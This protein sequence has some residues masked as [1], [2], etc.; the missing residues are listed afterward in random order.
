MLANYVLEMCDKMMILIVM[1]TRDINFFTVQ[2]KYNQ[3]CSLTKFEKLSL[4]ERKRE[5]ERERT[6]KQIK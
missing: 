4:F 3:I 2:I 1:I 6:S 5:R